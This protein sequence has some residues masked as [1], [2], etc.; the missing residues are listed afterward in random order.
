MLM[1]YRGTTL[2]SSTLVT[3][4]ASRI[5]FYWYRG[6]SGTTQGRKRFKVSVTEPPRVVFYGG[7]GVRVGAKKRVVRQNNVKLHTLYYLHYDMYF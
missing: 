5:N 4:R 2:P 7:K 1:P 3:H 6:L